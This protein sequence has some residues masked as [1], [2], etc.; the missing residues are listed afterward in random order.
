MTEKVPSEA[1][2]EYISE[3]VALGYTEGDLSD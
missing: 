3:M 1:D 2:L